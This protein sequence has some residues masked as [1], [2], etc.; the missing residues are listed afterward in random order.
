MQRDIQFTS[1]AFVWRFSR[2]ES[3][4]AASRNPQWKS[5]RHQWQG[6]RCSGK[7]RNK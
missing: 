2:Y 5:P 4:R 1:N 3:S 6:Q 7:M